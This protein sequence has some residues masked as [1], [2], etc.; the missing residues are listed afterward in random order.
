MNEMIKEVEEIIRVQQHR[1]KRNELSHEFPYM[2]EYD[3]FIRLAYL[4]KT[5]E[6][7]EACHKLMLKYQ[8]RREVPVGAINAEAIE[9]ILKMAHRYPGIRVETLERIVEYV[10]TLEW[11]LEEKEKNIGNFV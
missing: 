2:S 1:I 10:K 8:K 6:I 11:K 9:Q 4:Y 7:W 5:L 3:H